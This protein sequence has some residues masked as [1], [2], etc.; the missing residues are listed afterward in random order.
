V[1][2]IYPPT[3][4]ATLALVKSVEGRGAYMWDLTLYLANMPPL[5]GPRLDVDIGIIQTVT[6]AGSTQI[7]LCFSCPPETWWS[8]STDR[9]W[10]QHRRQHF[11]STP[12]GLSF[13]CAIALTPF[14]DTLAIVGKFLNWSMDAGFVQALPFRHRD[15]KFDSVG[16]S[17]K[18]HVAILVPRQP[19][20]KIRT[21]TE[22][23]GGLIRERG[24][25]CGTC[26]LRYL[27]VFSA[28]KV[29]IL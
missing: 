15:L 6:E 25:I 18:D 14:A 7:C 26:T 22:N 5:P 11:P 13:Q 29:L 28:T 21:S 4:C 20:C 23:V 1:S 9:D 3:H 17:M 27:I 16:L 2:R 12:Q 19:I 10:P 8:R 24:H